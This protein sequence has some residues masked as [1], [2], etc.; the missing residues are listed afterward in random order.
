GHAPPRRADPH[1]LHAPRPLP[2]PP[3][4][5]DRPAPRGL[6]GPRRG[7]GPESRGRPRRRSRRP[8]QPRSAHRRHRPLGPRPLRRRA[9]GGRGFWSTI[10]PATWRG[11]MNAWEEI[12]AL[13][14]EEQ[15]AWLKQHIRDWDRFVEDIRV[16][17]EQLAAHRAAGKPG[18]PPGW[19]D[20]DE[21]WQ[22][23]ALPRS[24]D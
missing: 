11:P 5:A 7:Q 6:P 22:Q 2:L 16:S 12:T 4:G 21:Y 8:R 10:W 15:T 9:V 20:V 1:R 3:A 23:R 18:L 24:T 14:P 19:I 13:S 17:H